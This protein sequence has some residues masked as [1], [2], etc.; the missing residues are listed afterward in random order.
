MLIDQKAIVSLHRDHS[1]GF[2]N[3]RIQAQNDLYNSIAG[4]VFLGTPHA[5]SWITQKAT[6]KTL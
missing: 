1:A 5:G 3:S 2:T 6:V 4:L